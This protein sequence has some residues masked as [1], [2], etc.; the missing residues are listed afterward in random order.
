M[1]YL[2]IETPDGIRLLALVRDRLMVG[3]LA[4]SDVALPYAQISR[5]HAELRRFN[6]E[7]W[8]RDLGST[9]GL[10][11]GERRVQ[12]HRFALGDRVL[13]APDVALRYLGD[14]PAQAPRR[15]REQVSRAPWATP[16]AGA[17][18]APPVSPSA[19][20]TMPPV[21]TGAGAQDPYRRT[22]PAQRSSL[23]H[24][25]LHICQTCGRRTAP[26]VELCYACRHSIARACDVCGTSLLPAQERCSRCQTLN[27]SYVG[28]A[29]QRPSV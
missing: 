17:T 9:N 10:H 28:R 2:Q 3:R 29:N 20:A 7:W 25:T 13:L 24:M 1:D 23:A 26:D 6:G 8:I 11:V 5:Q 19:G 18:G 27:P 16:P 15:L 21:S 14:D 4:E 12:Q 22:M